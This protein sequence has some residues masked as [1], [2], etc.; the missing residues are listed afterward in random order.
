MVRGGGGRSNHGSDL[1]GGEL[2][3]TADADGRAELPLVRELVL[4]PYDCHFAR[5][6]RKVLRSVAASG[7]VDL[8]S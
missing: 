5:R 4:G 8:A 2:V 1:R 3:A 6:K 7:P